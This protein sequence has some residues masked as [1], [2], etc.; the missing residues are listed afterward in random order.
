MTESN[1]RIKKNSSGTKRTSRKQTKNAG[2]HKRF[3]SKIKREFHDVDYV[4][5]LNDEEKAW[6]SKFY[7]EDLGANFTDSGEEIYKDPKDKKKAYSRNN[8]RNRDI[9]AQARAQGK[10]MFSDLT[11]DP[12]SDESY[13]PTDDLID[14]LDEKD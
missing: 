6:L 13:D 8:A 7:N 4:H 3:F 9:Y 11:P 14:L 5:K 1:K 12:E 2:L 10:L